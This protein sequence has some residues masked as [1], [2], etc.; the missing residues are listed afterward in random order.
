MI[1]VVELVKALIKALEFPQQ[2]SLFQ[3]NF[4]YSRRLALRRVVFLL[5]VSF[6]HHIP[7]LSRVIHWEREQ[8][9]ANT[10]YMSRKNSD[11]CYYT[12]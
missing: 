12:N 8:S 6:S 10:N 9:K 11:I 7:V 5:M 3:H 2:S 4:F 1:D